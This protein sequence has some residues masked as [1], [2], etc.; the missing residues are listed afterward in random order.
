LKKEGGIPAEGGGQEGL[1]KKSL[2]LS[3]KEAKT[4][5]GRGRGTVRT[6][7]GRKRI[8][9]SRRIKDIRRIPSAGSTQFEEL[10]VKE[11]E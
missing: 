11:G 9:K 3:G 5:R 1:T 2:V 7:R 4:L 10:Q 6:I 8:V